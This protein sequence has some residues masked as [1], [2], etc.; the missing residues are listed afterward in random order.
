[1][2]WIKKMLAL[3][4]YRPGTAHRILTGPMRG[5]HFRCSDNTGFAALY[6]GNERAN[7]RVYAAIVRPGD[8]VVDAGANWG[9]HALY[10]AR[11]VGSSGSVHA[12]EPHP[13]VGE[14]LRW[15]IDRN[16]LKQVTVHTCGLLDQQAEIPF[17]LGDNSKTS[18][19]ARQGEQAAQGRMVSVPCQ[20]LDT[21]VETHGLQAL[22]L[23][24]IDVEG[25]EGKLLKGAAQTIS[26]F[27]P[28]IVVELHSPEQDL[29]V[30][31]TLTEWGYK[32]V[33]VEGPELLHLDRPWPEPNGVWGTL[34]AIPQ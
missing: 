14:E 13:Q 12:F 26:R 4:W 29:E 30:A 7:Q 17:I 31:R 19:V 23:I 6:S 3:T 16:G 24:K 20:T 10:L 21:F 32:L 8:T 15:H 25:A 5:M 9:V 22:R 33:R 2:N 18:H 34:H 27:R 1:M 11:L 28:H